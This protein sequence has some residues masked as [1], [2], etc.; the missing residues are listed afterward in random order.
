MLWDRS[1]I[2]QTL[3]KGLQR[4]KARAHRST[5]GTGTDL[6]YTSGWLSKN[7]VIE[8]A[9]KVLRRQHQLLH[10]VEEAVFGKGDE[11]ASSKLKRL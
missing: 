10:L 6:K 2:H 9:V 7:E 11:H 5:L 3:S 8:Q 1:E 4:V